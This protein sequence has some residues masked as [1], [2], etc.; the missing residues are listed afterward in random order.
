M[1]FLAA[2]AGGCGCLK[3]CG[4]HVEVAL[5]LLE[6]VGCWDG[7]F[8]SSALLWI[9]FKGYSSGLRLGQRKYDSIVFICADWFM[10]CWL[11]VEQCKL[12]WGLQS[13]AVVWCLIAS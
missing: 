11:T 6:S 8:L 10:T 9:P 2:G 13:T 7:W 5:E 3:V 1:Y 12:H 4:T